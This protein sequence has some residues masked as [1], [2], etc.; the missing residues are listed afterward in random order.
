MWQSGGRPHPVHGAASASSNPLH[1][2]MAAAA[3]IAQDAKACLVTMETLCKA[4]RQPSS[5]ARTGE[6]AAACSRL[7]A[8][9]A[10]MEGDARSPPKRE[11]AD[12]ILGSNL[13]QSL[14]EACQG[15]LQQMFMAEGTLLLGGQVCPRT[16]CAPRRLHPV[17][18]QALAV[19]CPTR[20]STMGI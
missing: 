11:V 20:H 9:L 14:L 18:S 15:L 2:I 5:G 1:K 16:L 4:L 10:R 8:A 17:C 19:G 7:S 13:G 6:L 3:Q 12:A